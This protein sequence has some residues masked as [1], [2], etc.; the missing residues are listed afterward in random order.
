MK[1]RIVPPKSYECAGSFM[2]RDDSS[3]PP[4][5][6][7]GCE[8]ISL[9]ESGESYHAKL[10]TVSGEASCND[11][12]ERSKRFNVSGILFFS[13]PANQSES[14]LFLSLG[15]ECGIFFHI[16]IT[17]PQAP[18]V[19]NDNSGRFISHSWS[20][21]FWFQKLSAWRRFLFFFLNLLL[22]PNN[23]PLLYVCP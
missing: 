3:L 5:H 14:I 18:F 10:I 15:P 9:V 22:F 4:G 12:P 11:H 6:G 1:P 7:N 16:F 23:R 19:Y 17:L 20:V 2:K 8:I 13:S 21:H